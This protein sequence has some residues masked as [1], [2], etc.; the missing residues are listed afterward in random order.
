LI[1][2]ML[3]VAIIGLLATIAIPRFAGL[4]IKSKEAAVKG[5]LGG[6]RSALSIYY[7][8]N[9]GT[10]PSGAF[11]LSS[12]LIPKYMDAIPFI[13]IPTVSDHPRL[14]LVRGSVIDAQ[15]ALGIASLAFLPSNEIVVAFTHPDSSGRVGSTW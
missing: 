7:S 1:E 11:L 4:I 13:S 10:F 12:S 2:L 15:W 8:D 3:V 6:L 5:Q 9:E 14:N